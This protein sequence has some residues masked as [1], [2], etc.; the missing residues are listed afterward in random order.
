M[1]CYFTQR[2]REATEIALKYF[3]SLGNAFI[4]K[5]TMVEKCETFFFP[6]FWPF[7]F[8]IEKSVIDYKKCLF[9]LLSELPNLSKC[10]FHFVKC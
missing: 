3:F 1:N 2:A 6:H 8:L 5:C 9:M 4:F 10:L 7:F